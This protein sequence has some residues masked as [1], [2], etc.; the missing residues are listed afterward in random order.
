MNTLEETVVSVIVDKYGKEVFTFLDNFLRVT[1][2][3]NYEL[4]EYIKPQRKGGGTDDG[5]DNESVIGKLSDKK[6]LIKAIEK[7]PNITTAE[8]V[9]LLAKS[10]RTV[11]KTFQNGAFPI[12]PRQGNSSKSGNKTLEIILKCDE[13]VPKLELFNQSMMLDLLSKKSNKPRRNTPS[14]S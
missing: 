12:S 1:I 13:I 9:K 7:N 3:F 14:S 8:M 6:K 2:P 11:S 4:D 10:R 5:T